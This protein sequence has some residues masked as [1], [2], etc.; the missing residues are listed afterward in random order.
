MVVTRLKYVMTHIH[1]H[2]LF[3]KQAIIQDDFKTDFFQ[4]WHAKC[5]RFDTHLLVNPWI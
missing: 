2:Y 1:K 4:F 5:I 3:D